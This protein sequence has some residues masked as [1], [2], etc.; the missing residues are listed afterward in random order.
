MANIISVTAAEV[1]KTGFFCFMS[2]KKAPGYGKK[3][4]WVK[5]R[6]AEGLRIKMLEL[7][8]RGF[9]EYIPG[10][11]AWRGVQAADYMFIH[12]LWVVGKSKGQGLGKLLLDECIEDARSAGMA[13]VAMLTSDRVWLADSRLLLQ[14]GF[15]IV[16][17]QPP[18]SLLVKKFKKAPDPALYSD[19]PQRSSRYKKGLTVF[20]SDQCPYIEDA[21]GTVREAAEEKSIPYREVVLNSA[22]QVQEQAPS[23]YG[24]F[25]IVYNGK[26]LSYH[27]M[28]P[29][30]LMALLDK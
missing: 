29:K 11:L 16:E 12:C 23:P 10:E 8:E 21:A 17:Q 15:T 9:I 27:Y 13:G 5:A 6:L 3:M 20:R 22:R 2:K 14:N 1:D 25:S 28:L 7:P 26:L 18:F 24:V 30:D 4:Q 19:W